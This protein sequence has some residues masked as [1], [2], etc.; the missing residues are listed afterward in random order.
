MLEVGG[1]FPVYGGW[2]ATCVGIDGWPDKTA[3]Y[4]ERKDCLVVATFIHNS[5]KVASGTHR[6]SAHSGIPLGASISDQKQ[7]KILFE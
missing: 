5:D 4:L 1:V 7:A 2:T 6:H 3:N